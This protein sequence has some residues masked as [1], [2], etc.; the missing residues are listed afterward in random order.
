[1]YVLLF[2]F[3]LSLV[4]FIFLFFFFLSAIVWWNKDLCYSYFGF[5][6]TNKFCSVLLRVTVE[7]CKQSSLAAINST[8]MYFDHTSLT[9]REDLLTRC[10]S[11]W[12]SAAINRLG[13]RR[14]V[15][16]TY[17]TVEISWQHS[18]LHQSSSQLSIV[19]LVPKIKLLF[20]PDDAVFTCIFSCF[21]TIHKRD[22]NTPSQTP[23]DSIDSA[24]A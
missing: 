22:R 13:I 3:F 2:V 15:L 14:L 20:D 7:W 1:M 11:A 23:H 17:S 21:Y 12:P 24:S 8:Y 16:F 18:T 4:K 9:S 10:V 19:L 5:R 6:F